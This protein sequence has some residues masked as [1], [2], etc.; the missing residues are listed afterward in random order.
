M[1]IAIAVVRLEARAAKAASAVAA[2]RGA[3]VRR[4]VD[5]EVATEVTLRRDASGAAVLGGVTL[6]SLLQDFPFTTL[7]DA[8]AQRG[9]SWRTKLPALRAA[10]LLG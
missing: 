10:E 9:D 3:T 8:I 6:D 2:L 1:A 4:A 7:R 5:R